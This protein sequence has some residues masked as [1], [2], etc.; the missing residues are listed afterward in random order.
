MSGTDRAYRATYL[1]AEYTMS[2][3]DR[4]Y[5]ATYP[6][7]RNSLAAP[8]LGSTIRCV[9]TGHRVASAYADS[10]LSTGHLIAHV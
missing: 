8:K 1:H 9:S 5:R 7:L 2:G 10:Q 6:S 3:T 4:A